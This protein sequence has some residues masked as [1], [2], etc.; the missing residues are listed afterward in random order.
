MTEAVRLD[1]AVTPP[2]L[3]R[4]YARYRALQGSSVDS[5][6]LELADAYCAAR[7]RETGTGL[8]AT[9]V[10]VDCRRPILRTIAEEGRPFL[11]KN[12]LGR[13]AAERLAVELADGYVCADPEVDDWLR[14]TGWRLPPRSEDLP[15][16]GRRSEVALPAEPAVSVV[17]PYHERTKYLPFCLEGLA[18]QT[19]RPLE[20]VVADSRSTSSGARAQLAEIQQRSWPWP[21]RVVTSSS[22]EGPALARNAGWRAA[23]GELVSFIDDDDVPF[24]DMLERLWRGRQASGADV[25]V[26]GARLFRG[27]GPAAPHSEDVIRIPLCDPH[28]LGLISNQYGGPVALWPRTLLDQLGGFSPSPVE[29]WLLLARATQH[30]VRLTAPPDPVHWYRQT[31]TGRHSVDPVKMRDSGLQQLADAFAEQ[32]PD[33]LRLLPLLAAGAYAELERRAR[34]KPSRLQGLRSF[35]RRVARR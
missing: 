22:A 9:R 16:D 30:G 21:L 20:V 31:G 24:D 12:N 18:R 33:D 32:L 29:D 26:G 4:S 6:V 5:V 19:Y 23:Q 27:E 34:P 15:G 7:A 11:S 3:E 14:G 35:A 25:A 1:V 2:Y 8:L 28:E 17:V 13:I 10:V